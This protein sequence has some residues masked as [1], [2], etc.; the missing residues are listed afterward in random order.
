MRR[1]SG[2]RRV[3]ALWKASLDGALLSVAAGGRGGA[4][5]AREAARRRSG[6]AGAQPGRERRGRCLSFGRRRRTEE[7]LERLGRLEA[8]ALDDARVL[9]PEGRVGLLPQN[10]EAPA[11]LDGL[12][13]GDEEVAPELLREVVHPGDEGVLLDDVP[14]AVVPVELDAV[15]DADPLVLPLRTRNGR[16]QVWLACVFSGGWAVPQARAAEGG[17]SALSLHGGGRPLDGPRSLGS[18]D[19]SQR[20]SGQRDATLPVAELELDAPG[21]AVRRTV[22]CDSHSASGRHVGRTMTC[23]WPFCPPAFVSGSV[24]FSSS[25]L[26]EKEKIEMP[27]DDWGY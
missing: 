25:N 21:T 3:S 19:E 15:V 18:R 27:R 6:Q 23:S 24:T 22:A 2:L 11:L 7:E 4:E 17:S 1:T 20:R 13:P 26:R 8:R 5:R 14:L 12:A 10:H 16:G 9:L